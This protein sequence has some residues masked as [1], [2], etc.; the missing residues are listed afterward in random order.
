[1]DVV[2]IGQVTLDIIV[3]G[4]TEG[5]IRPG[6]LGLVDDVSL[7]AGGDAVNEASVLT[8][9]GYNTTLEIALG[10]DIAGQMILA[11]LKE[12]GLELGKATVECGKTSVLTT[13]LVDADAERR[14]LISK[15]QEQFA[16]LD[17]SG[18]LDLNARIVTLSSLFMPPFLDVD[19]VIGLAKRIREAGALLCVDCSVN[20]LPFDYYGDLWGYVDYFFPN[21]QEAR[22]FSK[23][24]NP[25]SMADY[26]LSKGI[27]N[28]IIKLG[29]EGCLVKNAKESFFQRAFQVT[30]V[31]TTGAGDAFM[32]GFLAG[33]LD[34]ENLRFCS[35][36]ACAAASIMVQHVGTGNAVKS[37]KQVLELL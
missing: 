9:M 8:A 24:E 36:M 27:G 20:G 11:E 6:E 29:D 28:V 30:A 3:R 13:V 2:C 34:S 23:E 4:Y 16:C 1:M 12:R 25:E 5:M 35:R 19:S 10:D 14:F 15:N 33:I 18:D 26:F 22:Y 32:A 31:D 7:S 17:I 37:K 21:E